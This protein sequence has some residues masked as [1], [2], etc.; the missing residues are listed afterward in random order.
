MHMRYMDM[1]SIPAGR[2]SA[3]KAEERPVA[4]AFESAADFVAA[5]ALSASSFVRRQIS[6]FKSSRTVPFLERKWVRLIMIRP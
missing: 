1:R 4:D 6:K 2:A 5:N 3:A